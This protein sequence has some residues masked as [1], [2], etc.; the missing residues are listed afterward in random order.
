MA[1]EPEQLKTKA[2]QELAVITSPDG[3]EQ[4]RVRYRGRKGELTLIL[5]RLAELP[6]EER[7]AFGAGANQAKASLEE[8]LEQ[9]EQAIS[10]AQASAV[11]KDTIDISLPGRPVPIGRLHPITQTI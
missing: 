1:Q 2:L 10:A 9:R 3:L 5:R 8:A 4:W 7:K 6:V 11:R